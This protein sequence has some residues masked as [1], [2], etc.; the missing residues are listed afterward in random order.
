MKA[1]LLSV[2]GAILLSALLAILLPEGKM[3]RFIRGICKLFVFS[4]LVSPLIGAVIGKQF[5]FS[6]PT[7]AAE[8]EYLHRCAELLSARD[9]A[10]AEQLLLD[11]FS[12]SGEADAERGTE[13]LFPRKKLT[14]KVAADG[15]IENGEHID[16]IARIKAVLENQLGYEQTEVIWQRD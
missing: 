2:T 11:R 14:V 4:V 6:E 10:L 16:M 8:G 5:S 1:Y 13:D 3:G 7:L 15:I 12:L 9:E